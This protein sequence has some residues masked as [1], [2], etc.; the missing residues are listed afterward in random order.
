MYLFRLPNGSQHLHTGDMR[1]HER[2]KSQEVFSNMV[3]K[4]ETVYLG[5]RF[6]D[7][8]QAR[9]W[10]TKT[11]RHHICRSEARFSFARGVHESCSQEDY[12]VQT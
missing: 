1:F 8:N 11:N 7:Y 4:L 9:F 2:F 10:L 6:L 5:K 3:N 12:T